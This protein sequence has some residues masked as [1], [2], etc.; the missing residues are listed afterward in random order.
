MT[1]LRHP[2]PTRAQLA[3]HILSKMMAESR[4]TLPLIDLLDTAGDATVLRDAVVA[5]RRFADPRA[6][7]AIARLL[8]DRGTPLVVRT[9]AVEALG[10]IGGACARAALERALADPNAAVRERAHWVLSGDKLGSGPR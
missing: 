3:I 6:V 4:A 2:E 9:A 10:Q 1:A 8:L 7:P 5:L